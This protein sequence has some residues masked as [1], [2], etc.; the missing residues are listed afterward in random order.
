LEDLLKKSGVSPDS[1][2]RIPGGHHA[3]LRNGSE[4]AA[5]AMARL[6]QVVA[7]GIPHHITQQGNRR[8]DSGNEYGVPRIYG[9]VSSV[10]I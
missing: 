7:P 4:G 9:G 1:S 10:L 5:E 2:R 6:A 3:E 8:D